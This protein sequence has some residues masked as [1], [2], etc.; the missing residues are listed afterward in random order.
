MLKT[1]AVIDLCTSIGHISIKLLFLGFISYIF[2]L[3]N[4]LDYSRVSHIIS[5]LIII[6][7]NDRGNCD[8]MLQSQGNGE[9]CYAVDRLISKYYLFGFIYYIIFLANFFTN[10]QLNLSHVSHYISFI[11][12]TFIIEK[13]RK[14]WYHIV[15]LVIWLL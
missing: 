11:S 9:L 14:Y 15:N 5:Y 8:I 3:N 2:I 1:Q 7:N 13:L 6:F 12:P 10:N 4:F